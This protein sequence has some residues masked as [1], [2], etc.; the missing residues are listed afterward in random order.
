MKWL[1]VGVIIACNAGGDL[2]NTFG[3]KKHGEVSFHPGRIG[4]LIASIVRNR[5]VIGGVGL[6]GIAFFALVT[7][8]SIAPVSFA[9]PA[10]AASYPLETL[11]ARYFLREH[12]NSARWLGCALVAGGVAMLAL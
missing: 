5:Y 10:T 12:V 6:M 11:L 8:L 7:L 3:M 2:L 4:W 9:I 1:L